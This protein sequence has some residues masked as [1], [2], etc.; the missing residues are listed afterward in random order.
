METIHKQACSR[1]I[2]DPASAHMIIHNYKSDKHL[3]TRTIIAG[4]WCR[5]IG[6]CTRGCQN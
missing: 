5:P 4:F 3:Q 6:V 2:I 1:F